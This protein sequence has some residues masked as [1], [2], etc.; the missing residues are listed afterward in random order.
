MEE[1]IEWEE[2]HLQ[3]K[4]RTKKKTKSATKVETNTETQKK[5]CILSLLQMLPF[6]TSNF[7][8]MTFKVKTLSGH[9]VSTLT[10]GDVGAPLVTWD[11]GKEEKALDKTKKNKYEFN[12]TII[13]VTNFVI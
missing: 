8:K 11:E 1:G 9:L 5:R 12:I 3:E 13:I 4:K 7:K 2:V 6:Y 10:S